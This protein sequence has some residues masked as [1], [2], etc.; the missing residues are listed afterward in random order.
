MRNTIYFQ[1]FTRKIKTKNKKKFNYE[2]KKKT[3]IWAIAIAFVVCAAMMILCHIIIVYNAKGKLSSN[4]EQVAHT[5]YGL[6]LGTTPQTR[7]GRRQN[8]FFKYRIEAA[9]HLYKAGKIKHILISGDENSLDGVNEVI[10][11]KDSLIA[12]GVDVNDIILDGKGYRT[13][14]AVVRAV[15]VYDIQNFVVV[16]QRFH[17]ERAIYLTE[18]LGLEVHDIQGYNAADPTSKMALMTY[19][20]EYLARVKVFVDILTGKEPAT[21]E[22]EETKSKSVY[23]DKPEDTCSTHGL[24]DSIFTVEYRQSVN[25]YNVK[26]IA[27]LASSDVDVIAADLTFTKNGKSFSLHTQCL[28]DILYLVKDG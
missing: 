28:G 10:C 15:K 14:D 7:I 8:E 26:A 4:I 19:V 13:L 23:N 22:K 24:N 27:K 18:H 20:R 6:L 1:R 25:G 5:E 9:E 3:I 21:Y 17:N 2:E 11:M 12:H 16:S